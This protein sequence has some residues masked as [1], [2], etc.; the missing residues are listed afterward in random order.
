MSLRASAFEKSGSEHM[1]QNGLPLYYE[2]TWKDKPL[3]ARLRSLII[4]GPL[5]LSLTKRRKWLTKV[6]VAV[7]AL[8]ILMTLVNMYQLQLFQSSA[9]TDYYSR[10]PVVWISAKR[11][12]AGHLTHVFNVFERIG[13]DTKIGDNVRDFD[14]LWAH[15]YPFG[16]NIS[17]T[18]GLQRHQRV[19]HFPGSGFLTNKVNL[20]TTPSQLTFI[21]LAFRLPDDKDELIQYAKE[22]PKL[23]WV[24]KSSDHRG[25]RIKS[26]SEM[27][28]DK[29][30]TF[31]QQYVDRP[32]LVDGR[33]FDI[34]LY[35]AITSVDPLRAYIYEGDWLIRF[36]LDKYYPFDQTNRDSYVISDRYLPP[37]KMESTK[38]YYEDLGYNRKESLFAYLRHKGED[39]L[40]LHRRLQEAVRTTLLTHEPAMIKATNNFRSTRSF[41]EM[42]RFDFILDEDLKVYLMEVNMSPNLS[43]AH[44]KA[45]SVLYEQVVFSLLSLVRV[46]QSVSDDVTKWSPTEKDM[47]VTGKDIRVYSDKCASED[48]KDSCR[49]LLCRMCKDCT[50]AEQE[51]SFQN[52]Y[53]EH[54]NR[55]VWR[56]LFPAPF[57][58]Q[59]EARAWKHQVDQQFLDDRLANQQMTLWFHGK[60]LQDAT[61]CM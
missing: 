17:A 1:E 47:Q 36:C 30:G 46:A 24:Q 28:L 39:P 60:C 26:L 49:T 52:A 55:R 32:Y 53:L 10:R 35:T 41:F 56:R 34:G 50:N 3:S 19:N 48:C 18:K 33:R 59:D 43:S 31:I 14:V 54:Q 22:N 15:D 57:Q 7:L 61:W 29:G 51:V 9:R 38:R 25:V 2:G 45:N 8:G 21:P 20:V 4:R 6:V 40:L 12:K 44:F 16:P 42:V 27:E 23:M 5:R 58:S 13:F 11:P 37:W